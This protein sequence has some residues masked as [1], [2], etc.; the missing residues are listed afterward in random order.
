MSLLTLI[1]GLVVVLVTVTVI[2]WRAGASG[3]LSD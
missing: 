2:V 1:A 3:S